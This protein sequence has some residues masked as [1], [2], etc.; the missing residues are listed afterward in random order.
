MSRTRSGWAGGGAGRRDQAQQYPASRPTRP[1]VEWHFGFAAFLSSEAASRFF[2]PDGGH[3]HSTFAREPKSAWDSRAKQNCA[4]QHNGKRQAVTA[5]PRRAI[6]AEHGR[7][8]HAIAQAEP[9]EF[10]DEQFRAVGIQC[11]STARGAS[12]HAG[13]LGQ[14]PVRSHDEQRAEQGRKQARADAHRLSAAVPNRRA[15]QNRSP[16]NHTVP[17]AM[18]T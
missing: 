6:S 17:H 15:I 3:E 8:D 12:S 5:H 1:K 4:Q 9:A 7:V 16:Q 11:L 13:N 2:K 10:E 18:P 14:P